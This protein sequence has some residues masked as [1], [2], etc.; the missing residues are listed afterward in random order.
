M[1]AANIVPHESSHGPHLLRV[2]GRSQ[3]IGAKFLL[4]PDDTPELVRRGMG[5]GK[6]HYILM[7][8]L[9]KIQLIN[10]PKKDELED[11]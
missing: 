2:R 9:N 1:L 10:K 3:K 6:G 11:H 5:A 4:I 7:P 8:T